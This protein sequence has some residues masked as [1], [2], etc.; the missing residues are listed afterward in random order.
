MAFSLGD[1]VQWVTGFKLRDV[2]GRNDLK[3]EALKKLI[4]PL[5][6]PHTR[7]AVNKKKYVF[8]MDTG[9]SHE[10]D[11]SLRDS[12]SIKT[13]ISSLTLTGSN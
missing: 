8:C 6:K 4:T 12:H 5:S 1:D 2:L 10:T 3:L 9:T 13:C 11:C 7:I